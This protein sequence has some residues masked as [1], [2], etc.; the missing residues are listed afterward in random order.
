MYQVLVAYP[1]HQHQQHSSINMHT[2]ETFIVCKFVMQQPLIDYPAEQHGNKLAMRP[3]WLGW[4]RNCIHIST[5]AGCSVAFIDAGCVH[6]AVAQNAAHN[7][8]Y[9][10]A[11][12]YLQYSTD[13]HVGWLLPAD[14]EDA[15]LQH[16]TNCRQI[17]I[18]SGFEQ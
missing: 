9:S 14:N 12:G 3:H 13:A 18:Q 10:K 15:L 5:H 1:M 17:H 7:A 16:P 2:L 8:Q 11:C 4:S 6:P